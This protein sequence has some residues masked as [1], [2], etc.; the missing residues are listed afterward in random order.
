MKNIFPF[1]LATIAVLVFSPDADSQTQSAAF[2]V[3]GSGYSTAAVTDYQCVGI[4]PANLG[5]KRNKHMMNAGF[6]EIDFAI[7]SE[8]LKRSLV[9]DLFSESKSFS[10]DEKEDA[11][12]NFTESKLQFEAN[13]NGA[14]FSFQD[15]K[16]GGFGFSAKER[17]MWDS[18]LNEE[19]AD[20][21]FKGYSANYFDSVY[22]DLETGDTTGISLDPEKVTDLFEGTSLQFA[23][24]RE[25][26]FSYGRSI[27][28]KDNFSLYGGVGIKYMKGYSMF[29]YSYIDGV[30]NATSA[31]NPIFEVDYDEESPSEINNN[32]YQPVGEGFGFDFG[33][34]ALLFQKLR[35]AVSV[36]D[37]GS[38]KWDGNVYEGEDAFLNTIQTS[39]LNNYNIF[40]L[41]DNLAFDNLKWG[42][43]EG[44]ESATT[45][46]P[47]NLRAGAAFLLNEKVEFGTDFYVPMNESPGSYDKM[48]FGLGTRIMPAK[49]IRLSTGLVSGGH[50]GTN[51]PVGLTLLPFNND[52][53]SWEIG[54]AIRDITTYFSQN[55]P[56]VSF[57][58][59]VM[60]FSFGG[61]KTE[62]R[63]SEE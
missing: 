62:E 52:G 14:G 9:S 7:Y 32:N 3:T 27:I 35:L 2:T 39:G 45:E 17:I 33:V 44:L 54:I 60:R 41:D 25:Y 15:E 16:I 20:I 18:F 48:I 57:A 38:I 12:I 53:F 55:K 22:Y 49:W 51:I 21:L 40:E 50:T 46:L 37:I 61:V 42:G 28:N 47:T 8:P 19:S 11:V 36:T 43:W 56:T 34:T 59:G 1:L 10:E 63:F 58:L 5:W 29:N 31:L 23:W 13:I 4:N 24:F 6:G 26:N 30:F